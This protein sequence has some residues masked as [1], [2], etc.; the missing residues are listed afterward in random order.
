MFHV[1]MSWTSFKPLHYTVRDKL[2]RETI[3]KS[4]FD[5]E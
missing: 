1:Y 5:M 4:D 3:Y 2:L